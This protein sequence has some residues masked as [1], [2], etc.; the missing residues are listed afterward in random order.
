MRK[1]LFL[2]FGL[3]VMASAQQVYPTETSTLD[4][5]STVN[6]ANLATYE[7]AN[8]PVLITQDFERDEDDKEPIAHNRP[9]SAADELNSVRF[10]FSEALATRAA[11]PAPTANFNALDDNNTSI[12]PDINAA[13]G[14]NHIMVTLNSQYRIQD[15]TGAVISTVTGNGFWAGT[16]GTNP[17]TF[18]PKI[19][20]D[21]Y[22]SRWI[23][24]SCANGSATTSALLVAVS[25]TSDPTGTWN[26]FLIDADAANTSWFDYPSLGF[27]K[28]WIVISG[29]MFPITGTGYNGGKVWVLN[30]ANAYAGN[31]TGL[32]TINAGTSVFT[33]C[34]AITY[35][36]TIST[37][38]MVQEYNPNSAGNAYLELYTITGTTPTLTN[39]GTCATNLPYNDA[40]VTGAPQTGT[41]NKIST[42][43]S[44]IQNVV[45]RNGSLYITHS[46]FLPA[47][48]P[49]RTA[50]QWWQVN[51]STRAV[52]QAGRVDDATGTNH[53]AFPSVMVNNGGD[54][55]LGFSTFSATT[56]ASAAYAYR[57][58]TD[59][60][61]T[62]NTPYVFKSGLNTYYKT[63]G[64]TSN[65]W[66]DYT[67]V[68]LDPDGSTFWTVQEYARSTVNTWGTWWAKV[69]GT[70]ATPCSTAP[71]GLA[72][73]SISNTGATV[74]WDAVSSAVSYNL[75]YKT[76]AATTWTTVNTTATSYALTGLTAS[77]VYNFQ[78]QAVCSATSSPYSTA[79]S[80]TTAATPCSTAPTGLAAA[81][82]TA[83]SATLS[84]GAVSGITSY[85]LQYKTSAATTWTT[86]S[87]TATSYALT[88]LTA[89]TTYNFQVQAV[90]SGGSSAYATAV[91]FTT[92]L[93]TACSDIGE[94]NN[95]LA[96]A[97]TIALNT[98][99]TALIASATDLDYYAFTTTAAQNL[100]ITLTNLPAD[101]DMRLYNSAGLQVGSSHNSGT[102]AETMTYANAPAGTYK[103]YVYGYS[104]AF[105]ASTC[106]TVRAST[107][108][109]SGCTNSNEPNETLAAAVA[110]APNININ[111]QIATATDKD[112]LKFTTTATSNIAISLTTLPA[113]FDLK[114]Y[115]SAGTQIGSSANG[116]TTSESI[117]LTNQAAGTYTVYIFGY[118]GA[119]S[120]TSCYTLKAT[121][122]TGSFAPIET[123]IITEGTT[124]K[125]DIVLFPNPADE[126]VTVSY[127][128]NQN[129]TVRLK[130]VDQMGREVRVYNVAL[131]E[132][133]NKFDI[134]LTDV[135]AGLYFVQ[136][137]GDG[138]FKTQKLVVE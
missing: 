55:M 53:Y 77:T 28:D 32:T 125:E 4:A 117:S 68:A 79:A 133:D 121:V 120:T 116:S 132:G 23:L 110:I 70:P 105:N 10:D 13:V 69:V 101:Y 43:D 39:Y 113:D 3:P 96:T 54:M 24:V 73:A 21:S 137:K 20:Y 123:D 115:N 2:L 65:R 127:H 131:M 29:N 90:C 74:S 82:I 12:P 83:S 106:Y 51:A 95:T 18:D 38:Y 22:N 97:Y 114:L 8:P 46:V 128:N 11:S 7:L 103:I 92:L 108:A 27:N 31:T 42:N 72:S 85:N 67:S 44:R 57:Y 16:G 41:T 93:S 75:Q 126:R 78:V 33:L 64:G 25:Q 14:P 6:M 112:Y 87:T 1:A 89:A 138:F 40:G 71:A 56:Y 58:S 111:G 98:N 59:A 48:T 17:S 63:Y 99:V 37:V 134:D 91:N 62:V 52:Q 118:N 135:A 130:V 60:A 107:S 35:D 84:W 122:A 136:I 30:K 66:G 102:T 100:S 47:T 119:R 50:V 19:V 124:E 15:K 45:Y 80:F 94:S 129:E 81:S 76:S 88:G 36:N 109:A 49:T 5:P 26:R 34:P 9:V 61:N 104:S 86:V